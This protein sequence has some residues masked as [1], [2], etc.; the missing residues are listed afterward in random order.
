MVVLGVLCFLS[1]IGA[2]YGPELRRR[3]P[4]LQAQ[5][6]TCVCHAV[7]V[8]RDGDLEGAVRQIDGIITAEKHRI[9]RLR[10]K[11]A[12]D[13]GSVGMPAAAG[14]TAGAATPELQTC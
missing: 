6:G 2:A 11:E 4:V 3:A 5:D 9:G 13:A 12:H 7:V 1:W 14:V 8:N 10:W